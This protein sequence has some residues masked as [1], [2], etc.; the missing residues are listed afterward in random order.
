MFLGDTELLRQKSGWI[1]LFTATLEHGRFN[2][3]KGFLTIPHS[4]LNFPIH[5]VTKHQSEL[6]VFLSRTVCK[7]KEPNSIPRARRYKGTPIKN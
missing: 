1:R 3:Y 4:H 6:C 5:L 2:S 7:I